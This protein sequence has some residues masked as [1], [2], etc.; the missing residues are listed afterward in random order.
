MLRF[1][2]TKQIKKHM[3]Y[4]NLK[5]NV[6]LFAKHDYRSDRVTITGTQHGFV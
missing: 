6:I 4:L 2:L 3:N 5:Y 1:D